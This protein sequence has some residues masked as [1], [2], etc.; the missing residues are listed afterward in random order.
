MKKERKIAT[1][2]EF[3]GPLWDDHQL[4]SREIVLLEEFL[5]ASFEEPGYFR[6]EWVHPLLAEGLPLPR[7][8][9]LLLSGAL[10]PN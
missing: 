6:E 2:P 5:K 3:S 10:R 7:V 4:E 1:I 8:F 9:D